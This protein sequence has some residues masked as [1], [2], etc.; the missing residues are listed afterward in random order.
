MHTEFV[1]DA[2]EQPLRAR[3]RAEAGLIHRSDRGSQYLSIH[4]TERLTEVGVE[5]SVGSVGD[6]YGNALAESVIGLSRAR[7]A[8]R[9]VRGARSK[10]SIAA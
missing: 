1:L 6:F 3:R 2:L 5:A 8:A 4:Y 7:R 9:A 10:P